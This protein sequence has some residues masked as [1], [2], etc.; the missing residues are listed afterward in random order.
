MDQTVSAAVSG[1]LGTGPK[2]ER[3]ERAVLAS[4]LGIVGIVLVGGVLAL[5]ANALII[6]TTTPDFMPID[7]TDDP[8]AGTGWAC[9]LPF[10]VGVV[11]LVNAI[12]ALRQLSLRGG[13]SIAIRG[14]VLSLVSILLPIAIGVVAD[15]FDQLVAACGGG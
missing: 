12:R 8:F 14:L 11:G 4:R 1:E 15:Q 5:L 3:N 10:I 2:P 7:I 9:V 6:A 13:K